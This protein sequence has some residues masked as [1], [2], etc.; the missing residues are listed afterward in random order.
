MLDPQNIKWKDLLSPD[1]SVPTDWGKE[2][3]EKLQADLQAHYKEMNEKTAQLKAKGASEKEINKVREK[4]DKDSKE[5]TDKIQ[6]I[7]SEYSYLKGKVGAYE[8]AGYS[9]TGLYR[10]EI[11]CMMFGNQQ[12]AFCRVCQRAIERMIQFYSE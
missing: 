5:I 3:I 8:G 6:Q 2:K 1:I 4:Y 10:P 7:R 9:A 11:N 12:K